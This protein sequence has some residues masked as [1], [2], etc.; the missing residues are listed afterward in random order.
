MKAKDFVIAT[1]PVNGIVV[2]SVGIVNSVDQGK[3]QVYFVGKNECVIVPLDSLSVIDAVKT[4]DDYSNKICNICHIFKPIDEFSK[5]Q[6]AAGDKQRRRPSCKPCRKII[7][8]KK[9][10]KPEKERMDAKRPP[11]KAVFIC[12]LCEKRTV[13]GITARI[14]ADHDHETGDGREW[15][16]DSCNTGLGRFKDDIKILERIIEYLQ[17]FENDKRI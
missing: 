14:V 5:N 9:L 17:R 15:I 8:G 7:D 4:G 11:D 13:V 10:T 2:H 16:C 6:N 12:P 1:K 3:A